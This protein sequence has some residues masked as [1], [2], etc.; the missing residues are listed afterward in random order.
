MKIINNIFNKTK[1]INFLTCIIKIALITTLVFGGFFYKPLMVVGFVLGLLFIAIEFS[2]NS[3]YIILFLSPFMHLFV[4]Y[5][6]FFWELLLKFYTIILLVKTVRNF[7]L[8]KLSLDWK[9]LCVFAILIVYLL[10]PLGGFYN[11]KEI[12]DTICWLALI[13]LLI[14]NKKE[15]NFKLVFNFF[16]WGVLISCL[17]GLLYNQI[18]YLYN[19]IINYKINGYKRFSAL[20][21][22]PNHLYNFAIVAIS[23]IFVNVIVKRFSIGYLA[24]TIPLSTIGFSTISKTFLICIIAFLCT[25]FLAAIIKP[26]K[27]KLIVFASTL[28]CVLIGALIVFGHTT[29]LFSRLDVADNSSITSAGQVNELLTGRVDLW[30]VY[31][32]KYLSSAKSIILGNGLFSCQTLSVGGCHSS[33]IQILYDFGLIGA[34]LFLAAIVYLLIHL[35]CFKFKHILFNLIPILV[36][37]IPMIVEVR[38]LTDIWCCLLLL[39]IFALSTS[40]VASKEKNLS[41]ADTNNTDINNLNET[42]TDSQ[43][44]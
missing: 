27:Y 42:V 1:E 12:R 18:P 43:E 10:L 44:G 4:G 31:I 30:K 41:V 2:A 28:T 14:V 26:T 6:L 40:T 35:N 37:T 17:I 34:L 33:I 29:S 16:V 25:I 23:I 13:Y 22:N 3:L 39:S 38:F 11:F 20:L 32:N 9:T 15:I 5:D 21:Y 24:Y 36:I 19:N 8:K 7:I